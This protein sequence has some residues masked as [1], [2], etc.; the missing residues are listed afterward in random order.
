MTVRTRHRLHRLVG[1][2]VLRGGSLVLL[3]GGCDANSSRPSIALSDAGT[4]PGVAADAPSG[5]PASAESADAR[6]SSDTHRSRAGGTIDDRR[7]AAI[8]NDLVVEWSDLRPRLAERSGGLVLE[9]MLLDRRLEQNLRERNLVVSADAVAAEERILLET[10]DPSSA[11]SDVLLRELRSAQGLGSKRWADLLRRN[12]ALRAL[13]A[14]EVRVTEEG[15][16]AA[17][18]AAHGPKRVARIIAL[19]DVRD[20]EAVAAQVAAGASF[21]DLAVT[22]STDRS[23][24]RGGLLAPISRLDPS[25]PQSFR[26]ALWALSPGEVSAPVLLDRSWVVIRLER[27]LPAD[28]A[29]N[30]AG[31]KERARAAVRRAQE[32]LLMENF[33]RSVLRDAT[34][35]TIFDDALLESWRSVRAAN[36]P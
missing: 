7:P 17:L 35:A 16:T 22:R 33:A 8:W 6:A 11:R 3:A 31:A 26:S 20:A 25:Y 18:D 27:E 23:A 13:V 10:L 5:R 12:A 29:I 30:D 2:I 36:R 1:G 14:N 28:A 21:A 4:S 15:V 19:S 9:E 34:N 32:R 24:E